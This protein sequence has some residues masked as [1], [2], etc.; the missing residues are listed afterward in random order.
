[1]T[2]AARVAAL[3]DAQWTETSHLAFSTDAHS[4][5]DVV[6]VAIRRRHHSC[7][8]SIDKSEY[9]GLALAQ[10]LG[11]EQAKPDPMAKAL[12]AVKDRSTKKKEPTNV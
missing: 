4:Y 10:L 2:P 6:L 8:I 7:V 12:E 11:F 3:A 5:S 9:D 1:M